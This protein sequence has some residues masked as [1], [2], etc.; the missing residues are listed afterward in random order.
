MF[1]NKKDRHT[2][3]IRQHFREVNLVLKDEREQYE[4]GEI[5]SRPIYNKLRRERRKCEQSSPK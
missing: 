3:K 2:E 5:K 4:R 1:K